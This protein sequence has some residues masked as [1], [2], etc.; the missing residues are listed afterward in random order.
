MPTVAPE[1]FLDAGARR[2]S[3]RGWNAPRLRAACRWS[4]RSATPR[5]G[6]GRC[7]AR[8][9]P[10]DGERPGGRP[11]RRD[12]PEGETEPGHL[13]RSPRARAQAREGVGGEGH[14]EQPESE[15]VEPEPAGEAGGGGEGLGSDLGGVEV[16]RLADLRDVA[17]DGAVAGVELAG[18]QQ[19]PQRL[20]RRAPRGGRLGPVPVERGA[21][22][23]G[24]GGAA[25]GGDRPRVVAPARAVVGRAEALV[26]RRRSR[27]GGPHGGEGGRERDREREGRRAD[28]PRPHAHRLTV[29]EAR[30][31]RS[32]TF[33]E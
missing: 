9:S 25:V 6:G 4:P 19:R 10:W 32:C 27:S 11:R 16:Q 20:P 17:A 7:G 5:R 26:G 29:A 22:A 3:S 2:R 28:P 31:T 8:R 24:G 18:T 1:A 21:L 33:S 23:A 12:E 30:V 14:R 13:R 15:E